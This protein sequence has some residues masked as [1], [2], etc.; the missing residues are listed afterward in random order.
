MGQG[1]KEQTPG[2]HAGA[3]RGH[4]VVKRMVTAG[5]PLLIFQEAQYVLVQNLMAEELA[6]SLPQGEQIPRGCDQADNDRP[7]GEPHARDKA[8]L[9]RNPQ[10]KH[11]HQPRY[12]QTERT[13][14]QGGKTDTEVEEI[15]CAPS[16][17]AFLP[18]VKERDA[19]SGEK[20]DQ[21]H[22]A[23]GVRGPAHPLWRGRQD[24]R[25][26]QSDPP[27]PEGLAKKERHQHR[28]GGEHG[29]GRANRK[30]IEPAAEQRHERAAPVKER[31]FEGELGAVAQGQDPAP[32]I[33]YFPNY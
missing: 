11:H 25:R 30:L 27:M 8:Q 9:P 17:C 10:E 2:Q 32:V 21:R 18:E 3:E 12:D 29:R 24:E 1:G 33:D 15:D 31:G 22:V 23:A 16:G 28:G 6:P 14:G 19:G 7:F 20:E 13:L 26:E 4:I 5:S